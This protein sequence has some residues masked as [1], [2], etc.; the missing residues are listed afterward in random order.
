MNLHDNVTNI[1]YF[2]CLSRNDNYAHC[3]PCVYARFRE[4]HGTLTRSDPVARRGALGRATTPVA[5]S[6]RR[7]LLAR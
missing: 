4:R 7:T 5:S 1:L 6:G 3:T 2:I